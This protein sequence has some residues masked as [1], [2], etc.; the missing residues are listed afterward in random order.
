MSQK[1]HDLIKCIIATSTGV[2]DIIAQQLF[3]EIPWITADFPI[4]ITAAPI[5]ETS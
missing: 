3:S 5:K 4:K 1:K 2:A